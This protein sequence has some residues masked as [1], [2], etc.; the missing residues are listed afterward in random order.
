MQDI[1]ETEAFALDGFLMLAVLAFFGIAG[2]IV[3]KAFGA[4]LVP[5]AMILFSGF[6]IVN[7]N[8]CKVVTFF[9]QYIGTISKNGF[10]W[11]VPLTLKERVSYRFVNFSTDKIKVNDLKGN[12]IEIAAIVVWRVSNAARSVFNVDD[13][14]VFVANQS[15]MAV[16]SIAAQYPYDAE[17]G[18]SL[19]GHTGEIVEKLESE[20]QEKLG[21]AGITVREVRISHL[22]YAP[23]IA[24]AMLRRQQA[25]AVLQARRFLVE[26]ALTIVDGVLAH[27]TKS[28]LTNVSDDQKVALINNLLV[29]LTADR[30]AHPVLNVG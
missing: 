22:A 28:Q 8:D 27:F 19:R 1:N 30:E 24:A 23:E 16:R 11:T 12:P 17:D 25:E 2:F 14:R 26:N 10:L 3:L 5:F 6:T 20:L 13:Y 9:G 29:T 18:A 4:I 15:D 7:P 21:I